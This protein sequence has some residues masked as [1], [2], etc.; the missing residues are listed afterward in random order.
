MIT[1]T[2][3]TYQLP[4]RPSFL[5]HASGVQPYAAD[6]DWPSDDDLSDLLFEARIR[7]GD[8]FVTLSTELDKLS[9]LLEEDGI[10]ESAALQR[11]SAELTYLD[12]HYKLQSK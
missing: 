11:I 8:Y 4:T 7:S 5:R 3:R 6:A 2:N 9:A 1:Q 12:K 10:P